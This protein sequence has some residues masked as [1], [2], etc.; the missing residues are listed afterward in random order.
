M[1]VFLYVTN[2][3]IQVKV[4]VKVCHCANG[5]GA[6]DGQNGFKVLPS[7]TNLTV[8]SKDTCTLTSRVN[9]PLRLVFALAFSQCDTHNAQC[10]VNGAS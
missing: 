9:R 3:S 10:I 2:V 7:D 4:A 8:V 5:D 6:F 1:K